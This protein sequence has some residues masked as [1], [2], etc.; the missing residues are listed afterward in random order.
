MQNNSVTSS[1]VFNIHRIFNLYIFN[2]S[3]VRKA[4]L[5]MAVS[6]KDWELLDL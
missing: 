4:H 1:V 2:G 3:N 5:F 6:H